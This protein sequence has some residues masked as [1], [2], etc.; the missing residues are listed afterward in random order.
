MRNLLEPYLA[1]D[2]EGS[3]LDSMSQMA[4]YVYLSNIKRAGREYDPEEFDMR[5]A[6]NAAKTIL[7]HNMDDVDPTINGF[8][9][10]PFE[11]EM[12]RDA[13]NGIFQNLTESDFIE[14]N[15]G[16]RPVDSPDNKL[17]VSLEQLKN[18]WPVYM[19]PGKY[20][21]AIGD[22]PD[23]MNYAVCSKC[24][25]LYLFDYGHM[26]DELKNRRMI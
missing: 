17:P 7:R 3:T 26:A 22:R 14:M 24:N 11:P 15:N 18:G 23:E 2:K 1:F 19:S 10:Q 13:M 12:T 9:T 25:S 8:P 4:Y 6:R 20:A 21:M 5:H 16:E